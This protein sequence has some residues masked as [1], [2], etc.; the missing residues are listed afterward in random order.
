MKNIYAYVRAEII[1]AIQKLSDDGVI[2]K[3]IDTSR[4]NVENCT[5]ISLGDISTNATLVL[6]KQVGMAPQ[7]FAQHIGN[8]FINHPNIESFNIS[9]KG[10]L[11]FKFKKDFW[12]K[13]L[14]YIIKAG[15]DYGSSSI[16]NGE[17]IIVEYVSANPTGPL[18]AAHARGAVYGD[19]LANLLSKSGF[20][21]LRE[22]YINDAGAQVDTLARS[23]YLRYCEACGINIGEIPEGYYPGSY[24]CEVGEYVKN[25]DGDIWLNKSEDQWLEEF[26]KYSVNYIMGMIHKDLELLGVKFDVYSSERS[27]INGGNVDIA[28]KTLESGGYIYEGVL[29]QPKGK[30][31]EDWEPRPQ[32]LFKSTMFGDDIDRPLKKSDG[33]NTYFANDIAYHWQKYMRGY[34]TM[35]DVWGADHIGYVK[36]LQSAVSAITD[37]KGTLQVKICQLVHLIK[38]GERMKMSKRDGNFITIKNVI[39]EVGSDIVRFIMLTRLNEEVLDFDFDAVKEH[40]ASNPVYYVHYAHARCRSVLRNAEKELNF[41]EDNISS[42]MVNFELLDKPEEV[43]VIRRMVMWPRI[44]ESAAIQHEPH[45]ITNYLRELS[46]DVH[47]LWSCGNKDVTRRFLTENVDLA[48]A[49]LSLAKAISI[50]ITSALN[51]I[52]V[53]AVERLYTETPNDDQIS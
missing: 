34:P 44:V 5:D 4:V 51:V 32:T 9:G 16:G 43:A 41:S 3:N 30:K 52:G 12:Y 40:S 48:Y 14:E 18:H 45:R 23:A 11:N 24:L 26:K 8:Y 42:Y 27:L 35:I 31:I 36:R 13:Q 25:K 6:T 39:D 22:Y 7:V 10:F 2:P 20:N 15:I 46:H 33:S 37:K 28:I 29:E 17:R 19:S 38:N 47:S 1:S 53:Q 21:V 50:V 49:R